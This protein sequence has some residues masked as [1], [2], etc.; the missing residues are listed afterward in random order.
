MNNKHELNSVRLWALCLQCT[1]YDI[2]GAK[3]EVFHV[4]NCSSINRHSY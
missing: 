3:G 1:F 2:L 4:L